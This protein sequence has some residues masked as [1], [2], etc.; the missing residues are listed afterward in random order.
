[1]RKGI[2]YLQG[3]RK[4]LPSSKYGDFRALQL[5]DGTGQ[6]MSPVQMGFK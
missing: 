4:I 1:M 2:R 6:S 3:W 5:L